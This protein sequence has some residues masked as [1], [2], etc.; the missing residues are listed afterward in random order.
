MLQLY[1]RHDF[2]NKNFKLNIYSYGDSSRLVLFK[3][4]TKNSPTQQ[5]YLYMYVCVY[6]YIHTQYIQV[7]SFDFF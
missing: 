2:Y 1:V 6:I 7:T 3:F 4:Y 5:T